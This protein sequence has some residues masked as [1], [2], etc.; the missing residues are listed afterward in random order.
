MRVRMI[1]AVE[2]GIATGGS[3]VIASRSPTPQLVSSGCADGRTGTADRRVRNGES[4]AGTENAIT[5]QR[6]DCGERDHRLPWSRDHLVDVVG[7]ISKPKRGSVL[8]PV[9]ARGDCRYLYCTTHDQRGSNRRACL[10]LRRFHVLLLD[11]LE[12]Q[13]CHARR[14][15]NDPRCE[16]RGA[17][18]K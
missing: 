14:R 4:T 7:Q 10:N 2:E 11:S 6:P 8:G 16:P 12:P 3:A 1:A 5:D 15:A 18:T 17:P 9:A 13:C